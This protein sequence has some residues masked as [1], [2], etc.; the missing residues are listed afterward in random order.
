MF[1]HNPIARLPLSH[2]IVDP[3]FG[4][5]A[6][7][8]YTSQGSTVASNLCYTGLYHW[9]YAAGYE[10][11]F[12]IYTLSL[13]LE[14]LAILALVVAQLHVTRASQLMRWATSKLPTSLIPNTIKPSLASKTSMYPTIK[15]PLA[16]YAALY[17]SLALTSLHSWSSIALGLGSIAWGVHLTSLTDMTTTNL[18][19]EELSKG[20]WKGYLLDSYTFTGGLRTDTA[21]LSLTDISHHHLAV[22]TLLLWQHTFSSTLYKA[23]GKMNWTR[24][25]PLAVGSKKIGALHVQLGL[26]LGLGS[27][28]LICTSTSLTSL[29]A[30]PYLIYDYVT[31]I[32]LEVHHYSLAMALLIGAFAHLGIHLV[33]D[34]SEKYSLDTQ[35][36]STNGPISRLLDHKACLISHLSWVTS[37]LGF[38]ILGL[39]VHNDTT[40]ALGAP[41]D[42]L[43]IEPLLAQLV[44]GIAGTALN[45][46]SLASN[47]V[48]PTSVNKAVGTYLLAP[49]MNGDL[50]ATHSVAFGLHLTTL[51]LFKGAL[52]ARKSKLMP[53]KLHVGYHF[54]C[55]GPARSGTCDISAWD[56]CYLAIFW[57]LNT[58]AWNGFY[59]H[60]KHITFWQDAPFQFEEGAFYLNAWF[61]DYLWFNSASLISGYDA[62][63][64]NDISVWSWV[65]LAAHLTWAIG[66]MFLISWRGFWQEMIDVL[67]YMHL[68]TPLLYDLFTSGIYTPVALSIVQA[69]FIGVVHFASGFIITY[70]AFIVGSTS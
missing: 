27:V 54:A 23:M 44:Q 26:S 34:V 46:S 29:P 20:Q 45:E 9:L 8:A 43:L 33:R 66:F 22:G 28:L 68:K 10:S 18:M 42:A 13:T 25:T 17:D 57:S 21:S 41:N 3:H 48:I 52:D 19:L 60:W 39:Y 58:S 11:V 5:Y 2:S 30:Y 37:W 67:L 14:L 61:R 55:D 35:A 31:C 38:H 50:L 53:D 24:Y 7:E 65:F 6:N 32:M 49:V 15:V 70:I 64:V 56:S 47:G 40:L 36:S 62:T 12:D 16:A 63:G 51:I 69:R 1:V 59:V 4:L